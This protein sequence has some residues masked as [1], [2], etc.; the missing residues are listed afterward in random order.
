MRQ[1]SLAKATASKATA[2]DDE[3]NQI[4]T[5]ALLPDHNHFPVEVFPE[6]LATVVSKL[7]DFNQNLPADYIRASVFAACA[8]AIGASVKS[9]DGGQKPILWTLLIGKPGIGKSPVINLAFKPFGAISEACKLQ[10]KDELKQ[11]ASQDGE[12]TDKPFMLSPV[13]N[14][15]TVE[16]IADE[17]EKNPKGTTLIS[18]E[19]TSWI[20]NQGRNSRGSDMGYYLS[21]WDGKPT[22]EATRHG[23]KTYCPNPCL[24]IIGGIQDGI[25]E[26]VMTGAK[27]DNGFFERWLFVIYTGKRKPRTP[28][29]KDLATVEATYSQLIQ[30]V[31]NARFSID[32]VPLSE[33]AQ[34][35]WGK[36]LIENNDRI[37]ALDDEG[38]KTLVCVLSKWETYFTR[39]ALVIQ[40]LHDVF[41]DIE[42][43]E[44]GL[45]AMRGATLLHEYYFGNTE[46]VVNM[47]EAPA[48]LRGL[49]SWQ[50]T[51]YRMLPET[52]SFAEARKFLLEIDPELNEDKVRGRV[53]RF[54]NKDHLFARKAQ[55]EY[56]K[57][58]S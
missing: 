4:V 27:L 43:S 31:Y 51:L 44:I 3:P 37:L 56:Q 57:R 17:L 33:D 10:Y 47:I 42:I 41:Y 18:D 54:L 5:T 35:Y 21:Y 36:W 30:K 6:P 52:F 46:A 24:N 50:T 55:G 8:S 20:D 32:E 19:I 45:D 34:D 25:L 11:Y 58:L 26:N 39:F 23:K 22:A 29:S 53:Q 2:P 48:H 38:D 7:V 14:K 9:E 16:A 28:R 13:H 40:V 15:S 12:S 1:V 49:S